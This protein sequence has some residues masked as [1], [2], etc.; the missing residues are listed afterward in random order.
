MT[1]NQLR[2]ARSLIGWTQAQV[3][4]ATGLSVPTVKRA[5]GAGQFGASEK[6]TAAIRAALESAGVIFL[7]ENGGG[8]G[9]RLRKVSDEESC[10]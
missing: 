1:G 5:E 10:Q 4:A 3:A 6:A 8:A 2:A 7:E 9:V